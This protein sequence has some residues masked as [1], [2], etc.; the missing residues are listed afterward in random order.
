MA[1]NTLAVQLQGR[2]NSSR[3]FTVENRPGLRED[4]YAVIDARASLR[5]LDDRAEFGVFARNLL[6]EEYIASA[7][8]LET[9]GGNV[10]QPG[11]PR[12]Y[13]ADFSYRFE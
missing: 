11:R 6:D 2:W 13:G 9:F 4:A 1:G 10:F 8:G 12:M 7:Y 3:F 5:F